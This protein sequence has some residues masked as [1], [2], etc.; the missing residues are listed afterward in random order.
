LI[1]QQDT[2]CSYARLHYCREF[3]AASHIV[4]RHAFRHYVS[5]PTRSVTIIDI[6]IFSSYIA[7]EYAPFCSPEARYFLSRHM[8]VARAEAR[9]D[10]QAD[11]AFRLPSFRRRAAMPDEHYFD[12]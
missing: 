1:R 8:L 5:A 7:S 3:S 6:M 2:G 11:N 10:E 9:H 12:Y 4:L